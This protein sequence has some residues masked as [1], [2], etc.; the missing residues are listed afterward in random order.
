[1]AQRKREER[2]KER[3]KEKPDPLSPVRKET[4]A[5][6]SWPISLVVS[7]SAQDLAGR[8]YLSQTLMNQLLLQTGDLLLLQPVNAADVRRRCELLS[9]SPGSTLLA[10]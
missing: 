3:D 9:D 1:M 7:P 6:I 4:P 8:G 10:Q 5:E 2:T